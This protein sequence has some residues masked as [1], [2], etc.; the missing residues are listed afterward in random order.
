MN[1][2]LIASSLLVYM[3]TAEAAT[4][5]LNIHDCYFLETLSRVDYAK[6]IR[7]GYTE[8]NKAKARIKIREIFNKA[9]GGG[10]YI[11]LTYPR[12]LAKSA[13]TLYAIE[14]DG[15]YYKAGYDSY[16]ITV[17]TP[18]T[19]ITVKSPT[20]Y[21]TKHSTITATITTTLNRHHYSKTTINNTINTT[22]TLTPITKYDVNGESIA[23]VSLLLLL[24]GG[25]VYLY[26]YNNLKRKEDDLDADRQGLNR[27]IDK[28]KA[29]IEL[30]ESQKASIEKQLT[31]ERNFIKAQWNSQKIENE[32][33][34]AVR[35]RDN[36]KNIEAITN[37][38][39][40]FA[41][42]ETQ[43]KECRE[44]LAALEARE[45]A[46]SDFESSKQMIIS[47]YESQIKV[48]RETNPYDSHI[49]NMSEI[50]RKYNLEL[51][52]ENR[53]QAKAEPCIYMHISLDG[54]AY[55]GKSD[56]PL[57]RWNI[58]GNPNDELKDYNSD[59]LKN[60]FELRGPS[61]IKTIWA[62]GEALNS[63]SDLDRIESE[64][65]RLGNY[66]QTGFNR[67]R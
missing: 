38:K 1:K 29:D 9:Q 56:N 43:L 13:A 66:T 36:E 55:V 26:G 7:D 33:L 27:E 17:K 11:K 58:N 54:K 62:T 64:L 53:R 21:K 39:W 15:Y 52:T 67:R 63:D 2:L 49:S 22:T 4:N 8:I 6:N 48:L 16:T 51:H 12:R 34:E 32:N 57:K 5:K 24:T 10:Y 60:M 41:H 44:K 61:H 25:G 18:P 47:N 45:Q 14:C 19:T 23:T 40:K 35:N 37:L 59:F 20:K 3:G 30:L 31:D 46:I 65:I 28:L 50:C 42:S